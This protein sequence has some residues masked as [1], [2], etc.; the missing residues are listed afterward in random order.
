MRQAPVT[1]IAGQLIYLDDTG[2]CHKSSNCKTLKG[3]ETTKCF[4][5]YFQK[6]KAIRTG[7]PALVNPIIARLVKNCRTLQ[8]TLLPCE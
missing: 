3:F 6:N 4:S 8:T 1:L 7:E 5:T 2:R